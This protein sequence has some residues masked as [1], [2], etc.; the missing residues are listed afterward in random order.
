MADSEGS[1]NDPEDSLAD[2]EGSSADSEDSPVDPSPKAVFERQIF[3]PK[4]LTQNFRGLNISYRHIDFVSMDVNSSMAPKGLRCWDHFASSLTHDAKGTPVLCPL[5]KNPDVLMIIEAWKAWEKDRSKEKKC[6]GK[7]KR[8]V[9]GKEKGN[10]K[11]VSQN[12]AH[13]GTLVANSFRKAVS[14]RATKSEK[15]CGKNSKVEED[16][17]LV[18]AKSAKKEKRK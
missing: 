9:D 8:K 17:S 12:R 2:S 3:W 14:S 15:K 11:V 18:V 6:K 13:F 4:L 10:E 5:C 16:E 1:S 7:S